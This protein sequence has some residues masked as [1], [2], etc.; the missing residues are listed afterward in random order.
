MPSSAGASICI[1][2]PS[3]S[4]P[5]GLAPG[6]PGAPGSPDS[7]SPGSGPD[8]RITC[9]SVVARA[10]ST[11]RSASARRA[12]ALGAARAQTHVVAETDLGATFVAP[13][14]TLGPQGWAALH[15]DAL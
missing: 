2:P 7:S 11:G 3:I 14:R 15:L 1:I 10:S 13:L 8:S 6:P 5:N 9:P 4:G 12:R